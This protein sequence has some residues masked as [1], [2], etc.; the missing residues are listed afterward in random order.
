MNPRTPELLINNFHLLMK[1]AVNYTSASSTIETFNE[2]CDTA[3][4]YRKITGEP[5][6]LEKDKDHG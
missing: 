2:A 6:P 1:R 5:M 4:L 3:I